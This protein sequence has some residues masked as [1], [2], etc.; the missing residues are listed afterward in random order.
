MTTAT[1]TPPRG[2]QG[3]IEHQS[4]EIELLK[5]QI[6]AFNALAHTIAMAGGP[7]I[8]PLAQPEAWRAARP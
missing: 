8:V 3:L 7:S 2:L 1:A 4:V 5:A 6:A